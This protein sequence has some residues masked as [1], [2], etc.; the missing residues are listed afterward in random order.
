LSLLPPFPS[1]PLS[2]PPPRAGVTLSCGS[3]FQLTDPGQSGPVG[4]HV[5]VPV[6]RKG[7]VTLPGKDATGPATTRP[8]PLIPREIRAPGQTWTLACVTSYPSAPLPGIGVPGPR[9]LRV[10]C[11]VGSGRFTKAGPVTLPHQSTVAP[12]VAVSDPAMFSAT[13]ASPVQWTA[14]GLTGAS[15]PC[16]P[17]PAGTSRARSL[18]A[19]N[20]G[21]GTAEAGVTGVSPVRAPSSRSG[22]ATT[23]ITAGVSVTGTL[24]QAARPGT[25]SREGPG[26]T[27]LWL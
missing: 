25:G 19:S 7:A 18:W 11:H 17:G 1:P 8:L 2:L 14:C 3:L 26:R 12:T 16:A 22:P 27:A 9:A 4:V 15:G 24:P 5:P 13:P 6:G 21:H 20:D 23:V 10:P